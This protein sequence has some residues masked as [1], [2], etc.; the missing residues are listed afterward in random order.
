[1]VSY[2]GT[3]CSCP[4][5]HP[6]AQRINVSLGRQQRIEVDSIREAFYGSGTQ[7]GIEDRG[8][9]EMVKSR[10]RG[11]HGDLMLSLLK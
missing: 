6:T 2:K 5:A 9:E 4:R 1:M 11:E 8:R 10:P 3:T 7:Q